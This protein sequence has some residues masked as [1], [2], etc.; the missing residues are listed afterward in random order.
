MTSLFG[1]AKQA[2]RES[3][4]MGRLR[5]MDPVDRQVV[6]YAEDS[7]SYVQLKGYLTALWS[8]H[9]QRF[10]YVTSDLNDPLLDDPPAGGDVWYVDKQLER[11]MTTLECSVFVTTM[12]DL[13]RFHVPRPKSGKTLYVFHSL[14]SAHTAYRSGAFDNYDIML[15][16]GSHHV[17]ELGVLR[18][19]SSVQLEE[20]GYYKLDLIRSEHE[21]HEKAADSL[22]T[23]LLAPSWGRQNLLEA[24]GSEIVSGLVD[25]GF[26]V[27][28][29]PHPQFFHSLYPEGQAVIDSLVSN[30][31]REEMVEFELTI[32]TQDSF[33]ASD[34]MISDWSG[35]AFEYA[36]GTHRPVL[37]V[38]TP[39][40][41]FNDDWQ[42]V[43][44][45]S[46]EDV[47]RSEVGSI[48]RAESI[49]EV[50]SVARELTDDP[51]ARS[52]QLRELSMR[53]VFNHGS[54]A[55][56]GAASIVD[57]I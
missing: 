25:S 9:H 13:G 44:L 19:G 32:D 12:P 42:T 50:G 55:S 6:V 5:T 43:G 22:R 49:E 10:H 18:S 23:V 24:Y 37:F 52:A 41:I 15:C 53:T 54:S 31:G 27:I 45:P 3:N 36:L 20:T 17:Q 48:L 40:K 33:H 2:M 7:F 57:A 39:Q 1:K 14:N 34:L 46:F 11:L 29:R 38:D 56:A 30:F 26:K 8:E 47:M 21:D 35:A 28:V 51:S 16:T 4:D